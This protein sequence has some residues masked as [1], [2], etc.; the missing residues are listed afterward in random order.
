MRDHLVPAHIGPR[1]SHA[2]FVACAGL[3]VGVFGWLATSPRMLVHIN[4]DAGSY[5]H[6]IANGTVTW[7]SPPWN[8]HY[9]MQY[10]YL[11][12]FWVV[13]LVGGTCIDGA[14]LLN[15]C[16][17][18]TIAIF[19]S[20]AGIRLARCRWVAALAVAFWIS[21]FVTQFLIFTLEDN[22]VFLA[23]AAGVLWLCTVREAKWGA[24][25]SLLAGF[26]VA[27]ATLMSIQGVI[28]VL[29]PLYVGVVLCG[30]QVSWL[31]RTRNAGYT[32]LAL[33]IGMIGF[34]CFISTTS[35]LSAQQALSPMFFRPT[36]SFPST[37]TAAVDLLLDVSGSLTTI[38]TAASLHVFSNR[39]P[40]SSRMVLAIFGAAVLFVQV[41]LLVVSTSW[42]YGQRRWG[43]HML[44]AS[45]LLFTMLTALYRD[46]PY[47]YLKRTDFAPLLAAFLFASLARFLPSARPRRVAGAVMTLVV[48]AQLLATWSWRQAEAKTYITLDKTVLGRAIPGYHGVPGEGSFL[49]HFRALRE[50]NP[51]ACAF[52]FDAS[53]IAYGRWNPDITANIWSELPSHYIIG[54][55][56]QMATWPRT[57][58]VLDPRSAS[59][60]LS[61]CEWISPAARHTLHQLPS[62]GR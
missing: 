25:E 8:A 34:A 49:R 19:L 22:I 15:A 37:T 60:A 55:P 9:G 11:V 5:F 54:N 58:R 23:P 36:S 17:L 20:D 26:L 56:S 45:L 43:P 16:C 51:S 2:L 44:A 41:G 13:R 6:Q 4:W 31:R 59:K 24:V 1:A 29:P 38:G 28:Y 12:S 46:V 3:L 35:A 10:V 53:E 57:M 30:R 32:L 47:A 42:C 27:L 48:A 21:A 61:G 52:V 18:A 14:R 40:Y 33:L 50:A 62:A 39:I 7:S